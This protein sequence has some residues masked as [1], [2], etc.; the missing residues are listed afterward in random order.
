M[1][2]L[3][4]L[5][6]ETFGTI[7]AHPA[8]GTALNLGAVYLV[9]LWLAAAW[10]A[11]RDAGS[12]I[13]APVAPYLVATGV[14][15]LTP[16]LFPL[17]VV[18]WRVLRPAVTLHEEHAARLQLALLADDVDRDACPG[19]G[20]AVDEEWVRCPLCRHRLAVPCSTC[21]RQMAPDWTI[22]AW[23]ASDPV[24]PTRRPHRPSIAPASAGNGTGDGDRDG[25]ARVAVGAGRSSPGERRSGRRTR[26]P[27][28]DARRSVKHA[29][30]HQP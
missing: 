14:I 1:S 15:L 13:H 26:Q 19:C 8:V 5:A 12:R 6:F 3:V 16:L 27:M 29:A 2:T 24:L 10:W 7:L 22:C 11:Y 17:A 20:V 30:P 9:I 4:D 23:C 28:P 25:G 21:D 18:V